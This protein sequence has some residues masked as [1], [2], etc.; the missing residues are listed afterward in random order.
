MR[1]GGKGKPETKLTSKG[2]KCRTQ[3]LSGGGGLIYILLR[4]LT[5]KSL[6][7]GLGLQGGYPNSTDCI[8]YPL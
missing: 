4:K 8:S 6:A 2:I 5:D 3:P 7:L 1:E